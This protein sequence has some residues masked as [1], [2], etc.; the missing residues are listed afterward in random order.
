MAYFT[1][2]KLNW[3][4]RRLRITLGHRHHR[5][6]R[7]TCYKERIHSRITSTLSCKARFGVR[8]DTGYYAADN[9]DG[10][11]DNHFDASVEQAVIQLKTD[12]GLIN[13]NGVITLDVTKELM[14]M[15]AFVLISETGDPNIRSMQQDLNRKYEDYFGLIP[16]DGVYSKS[17]NTALIYGIQKEEGLST[18]TAFTYDQGAADA[19]LAITQAGYYGFPASTIIYF[20]VDYDALDSDVTS[21]ILPYFQAISTEFSKNSPRQYRGHLCP[22]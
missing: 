19:D 1:R 10:L 20:A 2:F 14:S 15:D 18:A 6:I 13:P 4:L 7:P 12:V 11:L 21:Y 5:C 8:Y 17:T 9:P 16:C 22:S 3:E